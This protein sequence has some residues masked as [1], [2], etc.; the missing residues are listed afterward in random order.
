MIGERR[1]AILG[2]IIDYYIN[3]GEPLGSKSLCEMLPYSISS[4]TIRNEMAFL[5]NIG[6]LEQRH[7]SGG[8]VPTKASYRYYVDNLLQPIELTPFEKQKIDEIL[9]VNSSDPERL[10]SD[11][12]KILSDVTGCA[13]FYSTVKDPLDCVQ[14]VELIPAGNSKAMLV[15]LSVGGKI[16]SSVC[17]LNCPLDDEFKKLF[18]QVIGRYFVGV[19]LPDINLSLIQSTAPM[20]GDRIFDMLPILSSLVSLC[21]EASQG[22]LVINGETKLLSQSELGDS[23]YSLLALLAQ[24]SKFEQL[25]TQFAKTNAEKTLFIGDENPVYELR[26]TAMAIAKLQYNDI[27]TATLGIIGSLRIDYKSILPRVDYIMK[28]VSQL[29]KEGGVKYE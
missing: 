7:T 27:Q 26:N 28:T 4:A 20:L 23:V 5:S 10:L 9:S 11:A 18:Y 1:S 16:K 24:K 17:K 3:T 2:L 12:C 8:R 14:G 21:H 15:M 25:L 13:S 19:A 29:L 22:S 6:F